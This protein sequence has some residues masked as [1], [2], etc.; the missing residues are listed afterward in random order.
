MA[1]AQSTAR[2]RVDD[3]SG[4]PVSVRLAVAMLRR[5][6]RPARLLVLVVAAAGVGAVYAAAR[7]ASADFLLGELIRRLGPVTSVAAALAVAIAVFGGAA[8]VGGD[9]RN[10]W[11]DPLLTNGGD[12]HAYALAHIASL[13]AVLIALYTIAVLSGGLTT[14]E[15]PADP[16]LLWP[17]VLVR[18][19]AGAA[20]GA[21]VAL[22][23]RS[24]GDAALVLIV[25]MLG[26]LL[27]ALRYLVASL[28]PPAA[29]AWSARNSLL[30]VILGGSSS[31]LALIHLFVLS[32]L[33]VL[34]AERTVARSP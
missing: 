31:T 2:T 11:L 3:G 28:E 10:G 24:S 9:Q 25:A 26:P 23:L 8:R 15:W 6:V 4:S 7:R 30:M 20:W 34:L 21:V 22:I 33:L 14:G 12:R 17:S 32:A 16:L 5:D 19:A 13:S 27:I 18:I 29:V 1:R